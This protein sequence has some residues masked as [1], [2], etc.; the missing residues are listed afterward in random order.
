MEIEKAGIQ[1]TNQDNQSAE[2]VEG[3]LMRRKCDSPFLSQAQEKLADATITKAQNF[4]GSRL[5]LLTDANY[6]KAV[7]DELVAR[8]LEQ[9]FVFKG[10]SASPD[11]GDDLGYSMFKPLPAMGNIGELLYLSALVYNT[12]GQRIVFKKNRVL[13]AHVDEFDIATMDGEYCGRLYFDKRYEQ[14]TT[15]LPKGFSKLDKVTSITGTLEIVKAFPAKSMLE[16]ATLSSEKYLGA[17]YAEIRLYNF[18]N[19]FFPTYWFC[20]L[21]SRRLVKYY[22]TYYEVRP[23]LE[24]VR[25][26]LEEAVANLPGKFEWLKKTVLN[27]SF[28][29]LAFYYEGRL[30]SVIL[31]FVDENGKSLIPSQRRELQLLKCELYNIVPA[32][33]KIYRDSGKSFSEGLNLYY[34]DSDKPLLLEDVVSNNSVGVLS[35]WEMHVIAENLAI[36]AMLANGYRDISTTD[37]SRMIPHLSFKKPDGTAGWCILHPQANDHR[38]YDGDLNVEECYGFLGKKSMGYIFDVYIDGKTLN[39]RNASILRDGIQAIKPGELTRV[40]MKGRG[41]TFTREVE[42]AVELSVFDDSLPKYEERSK[43]DLERLI[44]YVA[45]ISDTKKLKENYAKALEK[46]LAELE[47]KAKAALEES[48]NKMARYKELCEAAES[49]KKQAEKDEKKSQSLY[50]KAVTL[51]DKIKELADS[52]A[53]AEQNKEPKEVPVPIINRPKPVDLNALRERINRALDNDP[54]EN[55]TPKVSLEI[56]MQ[57]IEDADELYKQTLEVL[58]SEKRMSMYSCARGGKAYSLADDKLVVVFKVSFQSDRMKRFDFKDY[59]EAILLRL[60]G[61]PIELVAVTEKELGPMMKKW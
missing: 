52:R 51:R 10:N 22:S 58:K 23:Y 34:T 46:E 25:K 48:K 17:A 3:F 56:P 4:D 36:Q 26:Q 8:G 33:F 39:E 49:M 6:L 54:N 41:A 60:A 11:A 42:N 2:A 16:L 29:V 40:K 30:I 5:A 37:D 19:R 27:Y 9:Q 24:D 57:N 35:D 59:F 43:T 28:D 32:V 50:K 21:P 38:V 45:R 20:V 18:D 14:N 15:L 13:C 44:N 61:R 31:D 1:S 53:Q 55:Q 7:F 12:N 47:S